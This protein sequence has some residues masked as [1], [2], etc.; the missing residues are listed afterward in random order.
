MRLL[1]VWFLKLAPTPTKKRA[2]AFKLFP[3]GIFIKIQKVSRKVIF[4]R[5]EQMLRE[6]IF[7]QIEQ[8]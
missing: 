1:L 8:M 6:V 2:T 4:K 5:I 7:I 3:R